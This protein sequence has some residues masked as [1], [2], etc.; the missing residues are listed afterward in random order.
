MKRIQ[1]LLPVFLFFIS[2]SLSAQ[3]VKKES[4][5]VWGNCNSCKKHIETAALSS[6]ASYADWNKTTKMLEISY[7][8]SKV[9]ETTIQKSI[10]SAGYDTEKYKGD[11]KAYKELDECCQYDRKKTTSSS[12]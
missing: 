3:T 1:Q 7:D 6:G 8:P 2:V 5:K 4:I 12:K 9:S 11:D 10:A